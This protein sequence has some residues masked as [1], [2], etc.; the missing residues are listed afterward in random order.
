MKYSFRNCYFFIIK[1]LEKVNNPADVI[2]NSKAGKYNTVTP[3]MRINPAIPQFAAQES[4][5]FNQ[6]LNT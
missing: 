1:A 5:F 3:Q 4:R 6:R 2:I